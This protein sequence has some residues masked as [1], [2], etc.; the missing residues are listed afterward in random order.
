MYRSTDVLFM[1]LLPHL[2][3]ALRESEF[4]TSIRVNSLGCRQ[5]EFTPHKGQGLRIVVVGDSFTFGFGVEEPDSYPRVLERQL[6][7]V[8]TGNT[9]PPAEVINAGVLAWWTDTYYLYLEEYG[10]ALEPDLVF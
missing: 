5:D 7:G 9:L 1:E 4:D 10:L 8:R 6:A 3:G 2:E